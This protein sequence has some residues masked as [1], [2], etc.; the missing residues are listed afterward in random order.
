MQKYHKHLSLVVSCLL[1]VFAAAACFQTAGESFEDSGV[2]QDFVTLT[3]SPLPDTDVQVATEEPTFDAGPEIPLDATEDVVVIPFPTDTET[4]IPFVEETPAEILPTEPIVGDTS[5]FPTSTP[6]ANLSIAGQDV[7]DDAA[8]TATAIIQEATARSEIQTAT[9][10][11]GLDQGGGGE[12]FF[13]TETPFV[14]EPTTD[15]GLGGGFA[16]QPPF[17]PTQPIIS[18]QDCI[19]EVRPGDNLFRLSLYYGI[20]IQDIATRNGIVNIQII[21]VGQQLV[22]PGCGTT[23]NPPP[24]TSVPGTY[25]PYPGNP[26]SGGGQV[27]IVQQYDNL[28]RISLRYGVSI[29]AI[30]AANGIYNINLIYIGQRLVIP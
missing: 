8:M 4:A 15:P 2:V 11:A 13:P 28:F 14:F 1:V 18:G 20:P 21:I 29:N 27:Y 30:A 12:I 9:A 7:V 23:G 24:P 25:P 16:T 19:H 10:Q 5:I 6:M 17:Q 26:G 3:P 22:I